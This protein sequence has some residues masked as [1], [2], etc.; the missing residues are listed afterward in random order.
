MALCVYRSNRVEDLAA[1]L[2]GVLQ[3]RLPA[4]PFAPVAVV[5]GSRGMADWLRLDLATRLGVCARV[6]FPFPRPALL[7]AARWLAEG[8]PADAAFWR[9]AAEADPWNVDALAFRVAHLLRERRDHADFARVGRYLETP[10]EAGAPVDRRLLAFARDAADA[11]DKLM[12]ELPEVARRWARQP[13]TAPAE[14]RWLAHLLADLGAA[15]A[16]DSPLGLDAA[17]ARLDAAPTGRWLGVFG[18]STPGPGDR[19]RLEAI[20]RFV[21]VDLFTLAPS[22]L[23]WGETA[24]GRARARATA[25]EAEARAEEDNP[26]LASLGTLARRQLHW[27]ADFDGGARREEWVEGETPAARTRLGRLQRWIAEA[28][29]LPAATAGESPD[30]DSLQ[31]HAAPGALRQAEALR[32]ALLDLFDRHA[33]LEPRDVLVMTPDVA[34]HAPLLAAV[35]ARRGLAVRADGGP[36]G[37]LPSIPVAITDLGLRATNPVAAALLALIELAG[38]R[39]TASRVAALAELGPV[40]ARLGLDDEAAAALREALAEAGHRWGLDAEDR[41]RQGLPARDANTLRF[42]A[43]RAALGVLVPDEDP[44]TV[45]TRGASLDDEAAGLAPVAPLDADSGE[46]ARTAAA[47]VR[48]ERLVAW[49]RA[50]L[51]G[52]HTAA[53]WRDRAVEALD[54]FTAVSDE[55]AWLRREVESAVEALAEAGGETPLARDAV[56]GW[57][58]GRFELPVRGGGRPMT[59][60]VTVSALQPMRAVPFRVVALVGMDDGAFPRQGS[61][62]A[63]D[64]VGSRRAPGSEAVPDPRDVDAHLLLEA[65][66]SARDTLLITWSGRDLDK[67]EKLPA[68]VPVE[69]LLDACARLFGTSRE[70]LVREHPLHPWNPAALREAPPFDHA[71]LAAA[72]AARRAGG[73]V[74]G[75][76]SDAELPEEPRPVRASPREL[77]QGL[78]NGARSWLGRRLQVPVGDEAGAEPEDLDPTAFSPGDPWSWSDAV[79]DRLL[80]ADDPADPTLARRFA[81]RARAEGRAAPSVVGLDEVRAMAA[82]LGAHAAALREALGR[83]DAP[84]PVRVSLLDGAVELLGPLRTWTGGGRRRLVEIQVNGRKPSAYRLLGA[85]VALLAASADAGFP[86]V[87]E[88]RLWLADGDD[89]VLLPPPPDLARRWLDDLAEAWL[90]ARRAPEPLF[91]RSSPALARALAEGETGPEALARAARQAWQGGYHA[92]GDRERP[93]VAAV[94]GGLDLPARLALPDDALGRRAVEL[95]RRVWLPLERWLADPEAVLAEAVLAEAEEAAAGGA[96]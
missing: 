49:A 67:N 41:R 27:I 60:A 21:D 33:D 87:A 66:L 1:R 93:E 15:G 91:P 36:G 39:V 10:A 48:L 88:A 77:A 11:L 14:D 26:I 16:A 12:H 59:G 78:Y 90:A 96:E 68:A 84:A 42:A 45:E 61:P 47:L 63:W 8:A 13:E 75:L 56:L 57:L 65:I 86:E 17:L 5:V 44:L 6:D 28:A 72:A 32:D 64:P 22:P 54:A 51:A 29:P 79:L 80:E 81:L 38:E 52:P 92:P 82:D 20:A 76:L 25:A 74:R 18:I 31:F 70:A 46:A 85:W 50:R 9:P 24:T 40:R 34:T 69:E 71:V 95:A 73:R 55:A 35:F 7:G 43:E 62:R 30:D 94:F 4:D 37:P 19:R 58:E 3:S 89:A 2:A 53:A 83:P 23:W